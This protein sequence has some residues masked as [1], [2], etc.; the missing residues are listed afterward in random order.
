MAFLDS[1]DVY[2]VTFNCGLKIINPE[3]LILSLDN[4]PDLVV[5]CLQEIAPIA[6]SFIGGTLLDPHFKQIEKVVPGY[7]NVFRAHVGLTALMIFAR[8]DY[9]HRIRNITSCGAG[10][11]LWDM[12]NK[13]GAAA[14]MIVDLVDEDGMAGGSASGQ[15]SQMELTF[16]AAHLAAMEWAVKRRN[17]DFENIVRNIGLL[18]EVAS[19]EDNGLEDDG[20]SHDG[21]LESTR[22]SKKEIRGLYDTTGTVFFA[23]DLNYRTSDVGPSVTGHDRFPQPG[24]P[25]SSDRHISKFLARDQLKTELIAGRV[26]QGFQEAPINFP[27]TYKYKISDKLFESEVGEEP[28]VWQWSTHRYPSW[29]DRVLFMPSS[30]IEIH[31]YKCLSIQPTSDHR[32]VALSVRVHNNKPPRGHLTTPYP[33]NPS[34]A[35]YRS[36]ARIREICVGVLAYLGL[37]REGNTI[38]AGLLAGAVASWF[39]MQSLVGE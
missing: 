11:G 4:K 24:H 20:S 32:P 18:T 37:T 38:M 16:V 8:E 30:N 5:I 29:T 39:I 6:Y 26:L 13:G 34:F 14:K 2:V 33:L 19:N 27:P 9:E 35:S 3:T 23:G 15:E 22:S 31:S 1:I 36:A 7:R 21:L 12:G 17:R 25:Q 10:V 28:E